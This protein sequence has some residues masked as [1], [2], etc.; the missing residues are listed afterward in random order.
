MLF[1]VAHMQLDQGMFALAGGL[2]FGWIALEF[3]I[4]AA[5]LCHGFTNLFS[6][7]VEFSKEPLSPVF[8]AAFVLAAAAGFLYMKVRK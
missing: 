8:S 7:A 1:A 4:V 5:V 2:V 6:L 3:G